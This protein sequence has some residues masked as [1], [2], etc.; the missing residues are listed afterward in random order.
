V[1]DGLVAERLAA[2]ATL[3]RPERE[4]PITLGADKAYDAAEF[5]AV[6]KAS[7]AAPRVAQSGRPSNTADELAASEGY[8]LRQRARN[9]IEEMF[10]WVK[11]IA[12]WRKT[13]HRGLAGVRWQLPLTLAA[14]NLTR[15][16][17]LLAATRSDVPNATRSTAGAPS[18]QHRTRMT[19]SSCPM[20]TSTP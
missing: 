10:A 12:G 5:V 11:S 17:K 14:Y 6:C 19:P 7:G 9:R 8:A 1:V 18:R 3:L 4:L 2:E 20:A 16:P 13:R 15:L